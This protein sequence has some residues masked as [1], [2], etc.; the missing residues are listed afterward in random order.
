MNADND[1]SR[2]AMA[3]IDKAHRYAWRY[4]GR[5]RGAMLRFAWYCLKK[6]LRLPRRG[7]RSGFRDARLHLSLS[8]H[9]GLG[10]MFCALSYARSLWLA[11]G[12]DIAIDIFLADWKGGEDITD[13][14][15]YQEFINDVRATP[16][17]RIGMM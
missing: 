7:A 6:A 3:I 17:Y 16:P 14:F 1:L 5:P 13:I 2:F 4:V 9:G 8:L 10:D 15:R 12:R 11:F